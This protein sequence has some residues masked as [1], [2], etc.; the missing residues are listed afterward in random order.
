MPLLKTGENESGA[1]V[2]SIGDPIPGALTRG[3]D[4]SEWQ[5]NIDWAA[6]KADDICFAIVRAA[7]WAG[8][9]SK[10]RPGVD[11]YWERN[12][13]ACERQGIP[14]GSYIYRYATSVEEA[15][16]EAEYL[17]GLMRGHKPTYPLYIDPR[18]SRI[19]GADLCSSRAAFCERVEQ[20]GYKAGIYANLNWW[21]TKL[22]DQK[23]NSW[24]RWVA[25]YNITS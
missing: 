1:W 20:L 11:V 15:R 4:V 6:V 14:Y 13:V 18:D 9:D 8:T 12:A 23:L 10:G 21:T 24:S 17:V 25:Q 7:K 19:A 16:F 2:N 22:T 5:K 3:V